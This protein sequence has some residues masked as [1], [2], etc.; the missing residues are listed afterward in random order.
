MGVGDLAGEKCLGDFPDFIRLRIPHDFEE[1][2]FEAMRRSC[3]G[4][5]RRLALEFVK[6]LIAEWKDSNPI[7]PETVLLKDPECFDVET[8]DFIEDA[9]RRPEHYI[10]KVSS[11]GETVAFVSSYLKT[12]WPPHGYVK[13]IVDLGEF[14]CNRF[15]KPPNIVPFELV[16]LRGLNH[17]SFCEAGSIVA[18]LVKD[19]R[20]KREA[21]A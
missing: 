13:G 20:H 16:L 7:M 18:N 1:S 9:F 21:I 6:R 11:F 3:A 19:W 2:W 4:M 17:V 14:V 8:F 10:P 5:D 15:N 12:R